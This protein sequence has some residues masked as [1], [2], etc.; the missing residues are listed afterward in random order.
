MS[1]NHFVPRICFYYGSASGVTFTAVQNHRLGPIFEVVF[2]LPLYPKTEIPFFVV[3]RN[4]F[5]EGVINVGSV[6]PC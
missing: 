3:V 5:P 2:N 4:E 6:T 1:K